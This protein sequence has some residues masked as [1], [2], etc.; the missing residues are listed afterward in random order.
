MTVSQ[1]IEGATALAR[2]QG[3]TCRLTHQ[4][5]QVMSL[6]IDEWLARGLSGAA[7]RRIRRAAQGRGSRPGV[8]LSAKEVRAIRP[9][10]ASV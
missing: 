6:D 2:L 1:W 5:V 7:A 10:K 8:V 4:A 9:A 3:R